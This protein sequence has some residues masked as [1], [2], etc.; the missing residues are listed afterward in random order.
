[1]PTTTETTYLTDR[2]RARR[3]GRFVPEGIL[4][5][6]IG[7]G[8]V[9][10]WFL[11]VDLAAGIPLRTP[12]LLG[13]ALFHGARSVGAVPATLPLVLGYTAVHLVGFV[14]LGVGVAGLVALAEREKRVLWL[15]FM[16]GCCLSVVFMVMVYVLAQ[17]LQQA[18]TPA[19]VLAGHVLAGLGALAVLVYRHRRLV[20]E[21]PT[22]A[23]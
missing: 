5:G 12:A 9:M 18:I 21:F 10:L 6:L 8:I 7:A 15:I 22:S 14:A 17:W 3:R 13:A 19:V 11:A 4:V 16:L 2:A 1:M 20:R 23:E